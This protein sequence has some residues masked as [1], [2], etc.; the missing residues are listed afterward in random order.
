M[1]WRGAALPVRRSYG[2]TLARKLAKE[3]LRNQPRTVSG[4]VGRLVP[5]SSPVDGWP[6]PPRDRSALIGKFAPSL[7]NSRS[8]RSRG[9]LIVTSISDDERQNHHGRA[10][11][12]KWVVGQM[13]SA[14]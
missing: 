11:C 10:N 7:E 8:A 5:A 4:S 2:K 13:S 6:S 3:R 9:V 1:Q 14:S 12:D